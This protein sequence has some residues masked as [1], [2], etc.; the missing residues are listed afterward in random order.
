MEIDLPE[1][2]DIEA[3]DI[4]L[5]DLSS[6]NDFQFSENLADL[7]TFDFPGDASAEG[8][9][10]TDCAIEQFPILHETTEPE[11]THRKGKYNLRKSLA[12]DSA[13]FTSAGVLDPEELSTM[14]K[15]PE[16]NEE[17]LLPRIEEDVS[18]SNESIPTF[19]TDILTVDSLENDLF[20]DIRA[21]IQ[22]SNK[23]APNSTCASIKI[24]TMERD[25]TAISSLQKDD[26]S[27][28]TKN[29]KPTLR[30]NSGL[31]TFRLSKNQPKQN[32]LKLGSGKAVKLDV[33]HSHLAQSMAKNGG[34]NLV[35]KPPKA[36]SRSILD[37]VIKQDALVRNRSKSECRSSKFVS[38]KVA[39][40][41]KP[42][43]LSGVQRPLPKPA[44]PSKSSS[45]RS[46]TTSRVQSTWS[47]TSSDRDSS[48]P[49]NAHAKSSLA[50]VRRN[51]VKSSSYFS[52]SSSPSPQDP[53][54]G[55]LKTKPSPSTLSA[56]VKSTKISSSVSP[57]SSISEWSS[58]SSSSSILNQRSS[59]SRTSL[60]MDSCRILSSDTTHLDPRNDSANQLADGQEN[61]ELGLLGNSSTKSSTRVSALQA[62]VR[63]SGLR[64]PSPK[65]GYFDGVKSSVCTPKKTVQSPSI[66]RTVIPRSGSAV[67]SPNGGSNIKLKSD[68]TSAA[69]TNISGVNVKPNSPKPTIPTS[70][71]TCVVSDEKD[72]P[73]WSLEGK[74]YKT[75]ES[76]SEIQ[77][78]VVDAGSNSGAVANENLSGLNVN[79]DMDIGGVKIPVVEAINPSGCISWRVDEDR[80]VEQNHPEYNNTY[81]TYNTSDKENE[82]NHYSKDPG[83]MLKGLAVEVNPYIPSSMAEILK[84]ISDCAS[85]SPKTGIE[86]P[87]SPFA[88]KNC[89]C[90]NDLVDASKGSASIVA[91]KTA[92][93][94]PL[95]EHNR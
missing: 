11:I 59:N 39:Q 65:F 52:A 70:F 49:S 61:R 83:E 67:Y 47:H 81:E 27:S 46:S 20:G 63:P 40:P 41:P 78:Q 9:D 69:R 89:F 7:N 22:R 57:A 4:S 85:L 50:A 56:Y 38:E 43:I 13:F 32:T 74:G 29:P 28:E 3:I 91:D 87:R 16:K 12:W 72:S 64:M 94:L 36:I 31:Q 88:T 82:E 75:G 5:I 10:G 73:I 30:K 55:A 80:R 34:S 77:K 95:V 90:D 84:E 68:K 62:P 1:K 24:E 6:Q 76:C 86:V 23:K 53:P 79:T 45:L 93:L 21:S 71:H 19:E 18:E 35:P 37:S 51:P 8:G 17:Q 33:G 2:I 66:L 92:L 14:L 15:A 44:L 42:S 26:L 54:R 48:M 60:E 25:G 58:V